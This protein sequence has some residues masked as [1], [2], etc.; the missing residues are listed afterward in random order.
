MSSIGYFSLCKYIARDSPDL[1]FVSQTRGLRERCDSLT[2]SIHE[3]TSKPYVH[4][5][6]SISP[7]MHENTSETYVLLP[8]FSH[9]EASKTCSISQLM[10]ENIGGDY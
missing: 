8:L 2:L 7:C 3:N 10:H 1:A 4:L 9:E 5:P 6:L